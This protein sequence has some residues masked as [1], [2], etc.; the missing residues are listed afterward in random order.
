MLWH[1]VKFYLTENLK[2]LYIF[3]YKSFKTVS[4][5][6]GNTKFKKLSNNKHM[7]QTSK[8][9]HMQLGFPNAKYNGL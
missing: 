3:W 7:L 4:I 1:L 9:E 2:S 5:K 8:V 6:T